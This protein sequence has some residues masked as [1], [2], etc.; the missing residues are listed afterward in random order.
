MCNVSYLLKRK[1][2]EIK[3]EK[4]DNVKMKDNAKEKAFSLLDQ[5]YLTC[6]SLSS[7]VLL[8]LFTWQHK[9]S[10]I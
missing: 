9:E 3:K 10:A 5:Q 6:S 4:E 2:K 1:K 7:D 8:V